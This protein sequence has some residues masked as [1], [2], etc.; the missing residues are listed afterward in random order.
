MSYAIRLTVKPTLRG[1]NVSNCGLNISEDLDTYT[2][3]LS[4]SSFTSVL[5][6]PL[7]RGSFELRCFQL[8]SLTAWLLSSA[9]P[10]N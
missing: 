1:A 10:D 7:F 4:I 6:M 8:L 9:F 2:P 5:K 3:V